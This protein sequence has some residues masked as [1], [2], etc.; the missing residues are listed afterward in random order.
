MALEEL[1]LQEKAS[2][3]S[4]NVTTTTQ[5]AVPANKARTGLFVVNISD[6]RIYVQLGRPAIVSTGIPLNAAGGAL[7]I[8]KT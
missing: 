3:H 5:Q 6:E 4:L 7:E 1:D 2:D 8:N